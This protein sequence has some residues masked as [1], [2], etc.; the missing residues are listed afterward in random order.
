MQVSKLILIIVKALID[1]CL[2]SMKDLE[3]NTDVD[4]VPLDDSEYDKLG[5]LLAS[6]RDIVKSFESNISDYE[7]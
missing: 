7:K 4:G 6:F 1:V 2:S 3:K 5:F